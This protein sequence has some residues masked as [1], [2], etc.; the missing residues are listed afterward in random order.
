[1]R[2][3]IHEQKMKH[4]AAEHVA[5]MLLLAKQTEAAEAQTEYWRSRP[6]YSKPHVDDTTEHVEE[7]AEVLT[8]DENTDHMFDASDDPMFSVFE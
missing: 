3:E 8:F 2:C 1:M 5:R 4:E 6:Q 7:H